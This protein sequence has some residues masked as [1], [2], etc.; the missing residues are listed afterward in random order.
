MC[1]LFD[2]DYIFIG[3]LY[4]DSYYKFILYI[5]NKMNL[6]LNF[7]KFIFIYNFLCFIHLFGFIFGFEILLDDYLISLI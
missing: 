6:N 7:H 3:Y 4:F 1:N 5:I 2:L